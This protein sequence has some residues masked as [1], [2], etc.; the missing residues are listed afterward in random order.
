[1]LEKIVE[2]ELQKALGDR[3]LSYALSTIMSRS[4]PDVRDGLKPVHRRLLYAMHQLKLAPQ[5]GYKKCARVVGD[6]MGKYHPHGD[7]AIYETLVRL[8]QDFGTRYPLVDGHGNFGNI[9]GDNAAA[10][11]YTEARLTS[12]ALHLLNDLEQDAVDFRKTYDGE[13]EEPVVLPAAFPNLL[14]N[15]SA[16]I[17]VGMASSIPPHNVNEICMA[18]DYIIDT[19]VSPKKEV[20][21]T[22]LLHYMPGPDFPTGGILVESPESIYQTYETGRGGF[23]LRARWEVEHLKNGLYVIVIT[24]IPYQVQKSRLIEK[25]AEL[26]NEKKL[27]LLQD[28]NDESAETIRLVLEP[29]SRTVD[30]EIL[31]ES[32]FRLTELET[33]FSLNMNVIDLQGVPKVLN[34]PQVLTAFLQHRN[35][36]LVRKSQFRLSGIHKRLEI[37]Q[38]YLIA[39]LNLDAIIHIIREEDSPKP[40]LMQQFKLTELQA[41]A[42]LNMRLRSLRKLEENQLK[43]EYESLQHEKTQLEKLLESPKGQWEAIRKE[44]KVI[45][46]EFSE[47]TALGKRRTTLSTAPILIVPPAESFI[48]KEAIT[49][50]CSTKNWIRAVKGHS[51]VV[52]DVKYK[53]G[54]QEFYTIK[55]YTTD[56]LIIFATNGKFYTLGV[57][58]INRG[59]GHGD[60]LRLLIDLPQE[61]EIVNIL[62]DFTGDVLQRSIITNGQVYIPP[63]MEVKKFLVVSG[64]GQ[65]FIVDKDNLRAQNKTGKQILNMKPGIKALTCLACIGDTV[66][67]IGTNRKLLTFPLTEIPE[68]NRGNGVRLQKYRDAE[69]ADVK[70]FY[71]SDG[72]SWKIGD[73]LRLEK[74]FVE[75]K[76]QRGNIGRFPPVGFPKNNRFS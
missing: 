36:V 57:D 26:L 40:I 41:E 25:M 42:I 1:M 51:L 22:Q 31:M 67:I 27:P 7:V 48:E 4:L 2:V 72:L 3:Y 34:L 16:G 13:S 59:K 11:R 19:F 55:A 45:R 23:R 66:A 62:L 73:R 5:L 49:V 56:K 12:V 18:L 68:M 74:H 76:G 54:D 38:G 21:L 29:R 20:S 14:A 43:Q 71:E 64:Q 30:P 24:E 61:E 37:L 46:Q 28:I 39:Y 75:W 33:R 17:A 47:K 65:G 69:V 44:I 35:T 58:K 52:E 10:M 60:P 50:L 32:L 9:D 63:S 15:G 6:V 8:A 53:E 70:I